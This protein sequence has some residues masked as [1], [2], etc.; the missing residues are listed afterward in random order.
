MVDTCTSMGMPAGPLAIARFLRMGGSREAR[1]DV[2]DFV[3]RR[4]PWLEQGGYLHPTTI[5]GPLVTAV[6]VLA[7]GD[8]A[9]SFRLSTIL[10][11]V[12]S[13]A[14]M[15]RLLRALGQP[16]E[17]VLLGCSLLISHYAVTHAFLGRYIDSWV[18]AAT[19]LMLER[20]H[21]VLHGDALW[22]LTAATVIGVFMK[23]SFLPIMVLVPACLGYAAL[24]GRIGWRLAFGAGAPAIVIPALA[25]GAYLWQTGFYEALGEWFR[26]SK[27]S[28]RGDAVVGYLVVFQWFLPLALLNARTWREPLAGGVAISLGVLIA[29]YPLAAGGMTFRHM[30]PLVP[31]AMILILP[32]ASWPGS[33]ARR[34]AVIAMHVGLNAGVM[35]VRML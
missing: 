24:R 26:T 5:I 35:I 7:T 17:I 3:L 4:G 21:A 8:L 30:L 31:M 16:L 33:F 29:F 34:A 25:I 11:T 15:A 2:S 32:A 13:I 28:P 22:S 6:S 14:L 10:A 9:L 18:L 20:I 23:P 12:L 1:R 19:L 27:V